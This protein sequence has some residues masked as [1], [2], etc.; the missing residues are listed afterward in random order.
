ML[1]D[2]HSETHYKFI[3]IDRLGQIKQIPCMIIWGDKDN[4]IPLCYVKNLD[5]FST[6]LN[7]Y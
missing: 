3:N 6:I 2:P 5:K 1:L 4:L 7:L